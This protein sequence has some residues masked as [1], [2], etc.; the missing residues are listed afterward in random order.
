[1][2]KF[3]SQHNEPN[4]LYHSEG[5]TF[6]SLGQL[7]LGQHQYYFDLQGQLLDEQQVGDKKALVAKDIIA[8]RKLNRDEYHAQLDDVIRSVT[9]SYKHS[10]CNGYCTPLF[11]YFIAQY[12]Q[13][14]D[15]D[16]YLVNE[17]EKINKKLAFLSHIKNIDMT[18][19]WLENRKEIETEYDKVAQDR[20]YQSLGVKLSTF[21]EFHYQDD[22]SSQVT[23]HGLGEATEFANQVNQ[24]LATKNKA[25][26]QFYQQLYSS[27]KGHQQHFIQNFMRVIES[28]ERFSLI[29]IHKEMY[30]H[31]LRIAKALTLDEGDDTNKNQALAFTFDEVYK[32]INRDIA[33]Y[34]NTHQN[35]SVKDINRFIDSKR[36]TYAAFVE[37]MTASY[38]ATSNEGFQFPANNALQSHLKKHT[39]DVIDIVSKND[40]TGLTTHIVGTDN[41]SHSKKE[42][43][44]AFMTMRQY[45]SQGTLLQTQYRVPSLTTPEIGDADAKP[46][47]QQ[48][49]E[50]FAA[51]KLNIDN[52]DG[53]VVYNLLTSIPKAWDSCSQQKSAEKI[54]KGMHQYNANIVQNDVDNPMFYVMNLPI[55]QHT[56][57]LNYDKWNT[58]AKEAMFLA[59]LAVFN[60][61][62][63]AGLLPVSEDLN[64]LNGAYRDFL[65][66]GNADPNDFFCNSNWAQTAREAASRLKTTIV[67]AEFEVENINSS[68]KQKL[69]KTFL[70][71]YATKY[72]GEDATLMQNQKEYASI[73]QAMQLSLSQHNFKGC[74]SANE[75]FSFI[76]NLNQ[77]F[78]A[79]HS[80]TLNPEVANKIDTALDQYLQHGN[81]QNLAATLHKIN[82][83]YNVYNSGIMPSVVDTGTPKF[84]V[85]S[86]DSD[87]SISE[88]NTNYFGPSCYSNVS[89]KSASSMQAHGG[90]PDRLT[91]GKTSSGILSIVRDKISNYKDSYLN[92][93]NDEDNHAER[94]K[95][96]CHD[97]LQDYVSSWGWKN[98]RSKARSAVAKIEQLTTTD[99]TLISDLKSILFDLHS[100]ITASSKYHGKSSLNARLLF[101]KTTLD[102]NDSFKQPEV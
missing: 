91:D 7:N 93:Y 94:A 90:I 42:Q 101:L 39:A 16:P 55:N 76:E 79:Y 89:Q 24:L 11:D 96:L 83:Q 38:L 88:Y 8:N 95:Q 86:D 64:T 100:D 4:V 12:F 56:H 66:R 60:S 36:T 28:D 26:D 32:L 84:N 35:V 25:K 1:M 69:A 81:A 46:I 6:L 14:I 85:S 70:K 20:D 71:L 45:D 10:K 97:V 74:K 17:V 18:S 5:H 57:A 3:Y 13:E 78:L 58:A 102:T 51:N 72:H 53:P 41:S 67:H 47:Q 87:L 65:N 27:I 75:R 61:M 99:Q 23:N 2:P 92:Q 29:P 54:F 21:F 80:N 77:L 73:I 50:A 59:D 44:P 22:Y 48:L 98:H 43:D 19:F 40:V 37:S 63:K 9:R 68:K 62:C 49:T 15:N 52:A 34:L 33:N 82:N 31:T 30:I